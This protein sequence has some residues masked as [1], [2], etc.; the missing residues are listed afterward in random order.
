MDD[1]A[2][3]AYVLSNA[4]RHEIET[5]EK[6]VKA[7]NDNIASRRWGKPVDLQIGSHIEA[8]I[9]GTSYSQYG[10]VVGLSQKA[11]TIESATSEDRSRLSYKRHA[12]RILDE[13]EWNR[14]ISNVTRWN[15][16]YEKEKAQDAADSTNDRAAAIR[17]R[18]KNKR[19][20]V[21]MGA[22]N[23]TFDLYRGC[24]V[25]AYRP[26]WGHHEY[27]VIVSM[28][29][30]KVYLT[31]EE[32]DYGWNVWV[33]KHEIEVLD[34]R[35]WAIVER[36]QRRRRAEYEAAKKASRERGLPDYSKVE[37]PLKAD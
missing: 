7:L 12:I 21:A 29:P 28:S 30:K 27:G 34:E 17:E 26:D 14:V 1:Q 23:G 11:C 35:Q 25:H 24:F 18:A 6:I 13:L 4:P 8:T 16:E 32:S 33:S 5:L 3:A 10:T 9:F 20:A 2:F 31:N 36:E 22:L 37:I 15:D 19:D